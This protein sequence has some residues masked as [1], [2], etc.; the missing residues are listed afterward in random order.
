MAVVKIRP[1]TDGDAED[2]LRIYQEGID[3]GNA[4]FQDSVPE[5]SGW[6]AGHMEECR[7]VAE[8][9]GEILGWA[10]LSPVSSRCVYRGVAEV[11]TYIAAEARGRGVGS[12]LL[13]GVIEESEKADVW[14]LQAGCFP[15][16]TGS[17]ALHLAHGFRVLY[18][19]ERPGRM[20]YG[21]YKGQWRD[22]IYLE[23]R[24]KVAGVD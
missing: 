22:V 14:T 18:Q 13:K 9:D 8:Q 3:T 23:R 17:L 4:T 19:R 11:S 5:W 21:P 6:C 24:S 10:A 1:M 2:V 20:S 15:E 7:L 12:L 16:N